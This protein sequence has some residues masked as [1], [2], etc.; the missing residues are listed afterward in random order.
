MAT[1]LV[2]P[3]QP[4]PRNPRV[5]TA[6]H[7]ALRAKLEYL[8]Q[9]TYDSV[10]FNNAAANAQV[11]FFNVGLGGAENN[12]SVGAAAIVA[13]NKSL[14]NTNLL[15]PNVFSNPKLFIV[16]GI[17]VTWQQFV[18]DTRPTFSAHTGDPANMLQMDEMWDIRN[19]SHL[20]WLQFTIGNKSYLNCPLWQVPNEY[21]LGGTALF[22]DNALL[23]A[24][25]A[26]SPRSTSVA[27]AAGRL[28]TMDDMQILLPPQQTFG[29]TF[30][31][32]AD[33]GGLI[34]GLGT[35]TTLVF[36]AEERC[37]VTL[38]GVLGREVM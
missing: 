25:E 38:W 18:S 5:A 33:T 32:D 34:H 21:G 1:A 6:W 2:N 12:G 22:G 7:P 13:A 29:V 14:L 30:N 11:F 28:Y 17:G 16:T 26:G 35:N 9:P 8:D 15:T 24:S 3:R 27:Q 20:T 19:Y 10:S 23:P 4:L 37:W 31:S 36:I